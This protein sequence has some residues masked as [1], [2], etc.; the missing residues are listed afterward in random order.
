MRHRMLIVGLDGLGSDYF[1]NLARSGAMPNLAS[2]ANAGCAGPLRATIPPIT[3]PSWLGM[4]TGLDVDQTGIADFLVRRPPLFDLRPVSARD[5]RGR[6]IWDIVGAAGY[7]T[8][9]FNFP[10]LYP[11]YDANGVMVSGFGT[12]E[13]TQWT[14]P[15]SL[16]AELIRAAGG[17][18]DLTVNYHAEQYDDAHRF[19]DDLGESI[20]RR[21]RAA[22]WLLGRE[23]WDLAVCVFSETDWLFHRCWAD[24]DPAA[25]T[26]DADRS[27]RIAERSI[28]LLGRID[29]AIP[30]LV[31]AFGSGANVLVCSDHGFGPNTAT[32]KVNALLER[33]GLLVRQ[34]G[35]AR[36]SA[37]ARRTAVRAAQRIGAT[38]ARMRGPIGRALSS[39]RR[40]ARRV[41]PRDDSAYLTSLID[42]LRSTAMD[43]GHTIPFGG[44][45]VVPELDLGSA[46]YDRTLDD[47]EEALLAA[48]AP[49]GF[50]I[51]VRRIRSAAGPAARTLPDLVVSGDA[52]GMSFS[53]TEFEGPIVVEGPF[54]RRHTGSHRVDGVYLASGP[55]FSRR[56]DEVPAH[57]LDLAPTVLAAFGLEHPPEWRGST[58]PT[59]VTDLETLAP[60][61]TSGAAG[62]LPTADEED[63][64]RDRLRG[65]GYIE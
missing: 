27:P 14:S 64:V 49:G 9:V 3:G 50:T 43:P 40:R 29:R 61:A 55:S 24:L 20:D 19:L 5:F 16:K 10:V 8:C 53:K 38:A 6:S 37:A 56:D 28:E 25:P 52:W 23:S 13:S 39:V 34:T 30:D 54:S 57:I 42:P 21:L 35:G 63:D 22:E 60:I 65:L 44:I 32:L 1:H 51:D 47:I 33:S 48:A 58:L 2:L 26:Y 62:D 12:D 18:Y 46:A 4:A 36:G 41:L 15:A 45:Y 31:R 7:R 17:D 59:F 11:P